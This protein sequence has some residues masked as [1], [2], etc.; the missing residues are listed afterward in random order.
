MSNLNYSSNIQ[1]FPQNS[2]QLLDKKERRLG[3]ACLSNKIEKIELLAWTV[4]ELFVRA[5][6]K[7]S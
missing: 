6:F 5:L 1:R 7:N 4:I 3:F 2:K